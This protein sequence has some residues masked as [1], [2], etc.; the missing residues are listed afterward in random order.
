MYDHDAT[1]RQLSVPGPIDLVTRILSE[2]GMPYDQND[3]NIRSK[4]RAQ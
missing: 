3:G 1:I 4:L 2:N